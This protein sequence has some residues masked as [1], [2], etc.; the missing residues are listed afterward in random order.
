MDPQETVGEKALPCSKHAPPPGVRRG[1]LVLTRAAAALEKVPAGLGPRERE[2][3]LSLKR[4][5]DERGER[6]PVPVKEARGRA[7]E[8]WRELD[9][10]R[11]LR[12]V[13]A[14]D[15]ALEVRVD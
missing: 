10:R 5:C 6:D 2:P 13:G 14:P 4:G 7:K 12:A 15:R 1:L 11:V 9:D 8:R 3:L